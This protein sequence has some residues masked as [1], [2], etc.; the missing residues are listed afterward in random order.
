[1]VID[2]DNVA[3]VTLSPDEANAISY[4][5]FLLCRYDAKGNLVYLGSDDK[6]Q[7]DRGRK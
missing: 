7:I 2:K 4:V 6:I 3:S 1:M 5:D